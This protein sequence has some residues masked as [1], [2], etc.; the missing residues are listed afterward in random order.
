[1]D[2][3]NTHEHLHCF[4]YD[5]SLRPQV[6]LIRYAKD[7]EMTLSAQTNEVVFLLEGGI[8]YTYNDSPKYMVE[9]GKMLFLPMGY[10]CSCRAESNTR[11]LVVRLYNPVKLCES[12]FIEHLFDANMPQMAMEDWQQPLTILDINPRIELFITGL[13]ACL[14]DGIKCRHYFDLKIREFFIMLRAYYPKSELRAFL[15]MILSSD[16][17]FSEYVRNNRNT[18]PTVI[19]LAESMHL[20]QKQFARRFVKVF[21]RTPYGW[22]KEGRIL[23]IHNK[24]TASKKPF[25]QVAIESGFNSTAQ[26]TKFCKKELG[27]TPG[28]LR[29]EI[30]SRIGKN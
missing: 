14:S 19:A 24:V 30:F 1:M 13:I 29:R 23:S 27:K 22:M 10:E 3:L 7:N 20:T 28:E 9:A 17:A 16:T 21:G 6:E 4:N 5:H 11:V 8:I 26:F 12:F 18:Y 15:S 25:K 2:L